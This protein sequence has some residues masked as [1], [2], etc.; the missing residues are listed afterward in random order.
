MSQKPY[1]E[2]VADANIKSILV[3]RS[4]DYKFPGMLS[5]IA[6]ETLEDLKGAELGNNHPE[7]HKAKRNRPVAYEIDGDT[8]LQM[9]IASIRVHDVNEAGIRTD[10]VPISEK[11]YVKCLKDAISLYKKAL[12]LYK[13]LGV[14]TDLLSKKISS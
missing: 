3:E 14:K 12:P 10:A 4:A 2:I 11:D 8:K 5:P 1:T 9:A 6:E 7:V 13:E